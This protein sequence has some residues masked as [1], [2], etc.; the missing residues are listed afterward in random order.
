MNVFRASV[1]VSIHSWSK[2]RN[3]AADAFNSSL[4]HWTDWRIWPLTS[5]S[6]YTRLL[7]QKGQSGVIDSKE[8]VLWTLVLKGSQWCLLLVT[9][10][11]VTRPPLGMKLLN[12][13]ILHWTITGEGHCNGQHEPKQQSHLWMGGGCVCDSALRL[14]QG[15]KFTH[16]RRCIS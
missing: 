8:G 10:T 6:I 2:R 7:L 14:L 11:T 4:E 12:V 9:S 3:V 5:L 13:F 15:A 1:L 16:N